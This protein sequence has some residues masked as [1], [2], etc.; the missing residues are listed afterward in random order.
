MISN[1]EEL[2][3]TLT[4]ADFKI[5]KTVLNDYD[6]KIIESV[7]YAVTHVEAWNFIKTI[8]HTF[9]LYSNS[10]IDKIYNAT[11][12]LKYMS[13]SGAS[14]MF[15]MNHM[16]FLAKNGKKTYIEKCRN[17]FSNNMSL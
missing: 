16:T 1:T 7:Y 11:E 6:Y 9:N 3:I 13:H 17:N 10:T 2:D 5:L 14:F 12:E 8:D 4:D 15:G